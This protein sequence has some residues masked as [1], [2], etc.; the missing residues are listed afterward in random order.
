MATNYYRAAFNSDIFYIKPE[1]KQSSNEKSS[2]NPKSISKH[3]T[4]L[5]SSNIAT[6]QRGK[7]VFDNKRIS[8]DSLNGLNEYKNNIPVKQKEYGAQHHLSK[9][10]VEMGNY[11]NMSD[12]KIIKERNRSVEKYPIEKTAHYRKMEEFYGKEALQYIS[13]EQNNHTCHDTE[14]DI[15][16]NHKRLNGQRYSS[17]VY[18][19]QPSTKV[20]NKC[21][22]PIKRIEV[23]KRGQIPQQPF[24]QRVN[25][26]K[27]NIFDNPDIAMLNLDHNVP[28]RERKIDTHVIKSSKRA[29]SAEMDMKFDWKDSQNNIWLSKYGKEAALLSAKERKLNEIYGSLNQID[30]QN[31]REPVLKQFYENRKEIESKALE[32]F[33]G[34]KQDSI[35]KQVENMSSLN[36][37][38]FYQKNY[39]LNTKTPINRNEI[40][41]N[42]E[43]DNIHANDIKQVKKCFINNG[44]H[45]YDTELLDFGMNNDNPCRISVKIRENV[46]DSTFQKNLIKAKE[47]L[48]NE[49]GLELKTKIKPT[50]SYIN[51]I[52]QTLKWNDA[53]VEHFLKNRFENSNDQKTHIKGYGNVN[54]KEKV[55][56]IPYNLR[57]KNTFTK[58]FF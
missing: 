45:I 23:T 3:N 56:S 31:A 48:K 39:Q 17:A 55:T 46:N 30:I 4:S 5:V 58:N 53:N 37:T 34:S 14:I 12:H 1:Q 33:Q 27:S 16:G 24:E 57:Y 44:I 32:H 41:H 51:S 25:F 15:F 7:D 13:N 22:G 52:P 21:K 8:S 2:F 35:Q 26:L 19:T 50:K 40:I 43:I 29:N 42:Y 49:K 20:Q 38:D 18:L 54:K 9:S 10:Q 6:E 36:G 11:D 28:L 47:T